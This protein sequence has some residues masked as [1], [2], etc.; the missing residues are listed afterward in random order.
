LGALEDLGE[1]VDIIVTIGIWVVVVDEGAFAHWATLSRD[2]SAFVESFAK[3]TRVIL[4][5]CENFQS[6]D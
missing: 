4:E 6:C 5:T 2:S 3:N 1:L